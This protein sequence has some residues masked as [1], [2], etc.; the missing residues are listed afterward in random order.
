M[1]QM[2]TI[3]IEFLLYTYIY[4]L[5]VFIIY[6]II[7]FFKLYFSSSVV[8]LAFFLLMSFRFLN[9]GSFSEARFLFK[10]GHVI[11]ICEMREEGQ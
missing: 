9:T 6:Y 2:L 5:Y 4:F 8:P 1:P 11:Y 3:K 7:Y 10:A